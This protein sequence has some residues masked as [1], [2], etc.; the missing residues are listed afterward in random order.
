[1]NQLGRL[2]DLR[3]AARV[4]RAASEPM[5]FD[6]E[7]LAANIIYRFTGEHV[8]LQDD[9][10]ADAMPDIRIDY[11]DGRVGYVEVW[12]DLDGPYA[13]MTRA[14]AEN[15]YQL[16]A[17]GLGRVWFLEVSSRFRMS[18]AIRDVPEVLKALTEEGNTFTIIGTAETLQRHPSPHVQRAL[19]MGIVSLAS[20][21]ASM[22]EPEAVHLGP[23]GI[24]GPADVTWEPFLEW[25][26]QTLS[27]TD[28]HMAGNRRKLAAAG[29][30][31]SHAFLGPT[32]SSSWA[33]FHALTYWSNTLPPAPPRLPREITHVWLLNP[34]TP[35]RCLAWL[36][37]RG[38]ID[39]SMHWAVS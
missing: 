22:N 38:W 7:F 14:L 23:Q 26:E 39:P 18:S 31:E 12:K 11:A 2:E 35:D 1:M 5:T 36:P 24:R 17:D 10:S 30:D 19:E 28:P 34:Q 37:D 13:A 27:S 25:I 16:P 9:G 3:P 15:G 4:A 21:P 8:V 32:Y 20:R 29:G 33:V 6:F